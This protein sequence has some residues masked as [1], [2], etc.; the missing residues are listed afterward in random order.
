MVS[1]SCNCSFRELI[2]ERQ[3]CEAIA[4]DTIL[5]WLQV[6]TNAEDSV[7]TEKHRVSIGRLNGEVSLVFGQ[8]FLDPIDLS[9]SADGQLKLKQVLE[10]YRPIPAK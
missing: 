7:E 2:V 9:L 8:V 1:W 6:L 10:A 4:R 5:K 3:V